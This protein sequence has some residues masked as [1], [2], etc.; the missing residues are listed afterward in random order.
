ML[1]NNAFWK[2]PDVS[3]ISHHD[4]NRLGFIFS[5]ASIPTW[6]TQYP[7]DTPLLT[8]WVGGKQAEDLAAKGEETILETAIQSLAAIFMITVTEV[9]DQL[10]SS[11]IFDW[12]NDPYSRGAYSFEVVEGMKLKE[13]MRD[14]EEDTLYFAGEGYHE[15][16]NAGTVEAAL[17]EGFR[18]AR[19][20]A[21]DLS[22]GP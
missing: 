6:W 22:Q 10:L 2:R 7:D 1:F 11:K 8:G 21:L 17:S 18:V 14:P 16:S 12:V 3:R 19:T 13:V 15:G 4:L 5:D 9:K 20:I